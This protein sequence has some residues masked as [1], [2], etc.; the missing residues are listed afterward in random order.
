MKSVLI[1]LL[2]LAGCGNA[3]DTT[4]KSP[5]YIP[6]KVDKFE[7]HIYRISDSEHVVIMDIPDKFVPRRCAVYVNELT[8]TSSSFNCNFDSAGEPMP[9]DNE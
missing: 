8:K 3:A 7:S 4:G 6:P 9:G 1:I 2:L 5:V